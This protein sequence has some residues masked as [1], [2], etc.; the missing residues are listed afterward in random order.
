MKSHRPAPLLNFV[1]MQQRGIA[2]LPSDSPFTNEADLKELPHTLDGSFAW[3]TK[4]P[5]H[6]EW[7]IGERSAS[8]LPAQLKSVIASARR[9]GITLPGEEKRTQLVFS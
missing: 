9:H 4:T 8:K 3:L 1:V 7:A 2:M 5:R 6:R